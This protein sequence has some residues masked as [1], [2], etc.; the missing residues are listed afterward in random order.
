MENCNFKEKDGVIRDKIVFL[1][2]G[3]L[4]WLLCHE[5][6]LDLNKTFKICL[7]LEATTRYAKDI[8]ISE[9][10]QSVNRVGS[11]KWK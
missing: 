8:C 9:R 6:D 4:Q 10:N 1:T 11:F 3:K 2:S 5:R 7:S